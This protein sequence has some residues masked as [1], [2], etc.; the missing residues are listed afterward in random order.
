MEDDGHDKQRARTVGDE[1]SKA[2]RMAVSSPLSVYRGPAGDHNDRAMQAVVELGRVLSVRLAAD[3]VP[4]GQPLPADPA[5]WNVELERAR[6]SLRLMADRMQEI[7]AG[8]PTPVTAMTRCAVALATLPPVLAHHP[9]ALVVWLDAHGDIN[10]PGDSQTGYLGGLALSGLMGWWDSGLGAGLRSDHAILVGSR[11]LDPAEAEH[12]DSGRV[13]LVP[14]GPGIGARLAE[15]IAGRPVYLHL[16]CDVFQPGLVATDYTV[17]DG[18][19]LDDV[20]D[21]AVAVS[22]GRVVGVEIAEYEGPGSAG[23]SELLDALEPIL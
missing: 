19:T 22:S 12:V 3:A 8:G 6:P 10:V 17:P 15:E 21:C 7:L 18:L 4:V 1:A 11:D 20:H 9:E 16:D 2:G 14:P 23:P 13:L 5:A